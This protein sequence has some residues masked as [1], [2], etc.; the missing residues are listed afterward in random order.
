VFVSHDSGSVQPVSE[1]RKE[2]R[3]HLR[4]IDLKVVQLFALVCEGLS[5][6]TRALRNGDAGALK[7]VAEREEVV[8]GLH[9][10]LETLRITRNVLVDTQGHL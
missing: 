6:A 2:F 3:Q 8:D 4:T 1:L 5:V 9:R 10:E 7:V